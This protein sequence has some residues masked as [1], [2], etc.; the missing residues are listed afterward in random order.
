MFY[1]IFQAQNAA[2]FDGGLGANEQRTEPYTKYGEGV[3]EFATTHDAKNTGK[4]LG[5][6]QKL[7]SVAGGVYA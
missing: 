1:K 4:L 2:C 3:A 5:F 6:A 7:V